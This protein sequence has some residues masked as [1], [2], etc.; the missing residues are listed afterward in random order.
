MG[1]V[2]LHREA[3]SPALFELLQALMQDM[4]LDAFYLVGGTSLSLRFAHRTSVDIDLFTHHPFDAQALA[5][6]LKEHY[7][8]V[9]TETA[10]NTVSGVV[11]GIKVDLIAHRYPILEPVETIEG[12]RLAAV[13]DVAAMKLNAIA[14]R[15]SK[16]DFWDCAELLG[17][18]PM[19][20]LLEY[21]ARKYTGDSLWNVEKSLCYFDDAENDPQP[22]DLRGQTWEQVKTIIA[23][24]NRL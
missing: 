12:L 2:T 23:E 14:N 13:A 17:T 24:H 3:V 9:E 6:W 15:G 7:G 21:Y 8:M 22:R 10:E 20:T 1:P 16:K 5:A 11:S 4:R 19:A 18:T